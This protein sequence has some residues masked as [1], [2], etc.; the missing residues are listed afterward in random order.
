MN[1]KELINLLE[2]LSQVNENA[3]VLVNNKEISSNNISLTGDLKYLLI[4]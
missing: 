3:E 1:I 2:E 4:N